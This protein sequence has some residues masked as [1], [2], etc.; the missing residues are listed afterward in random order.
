MLTAQ[1]GGVQPLV[2]RVDC[3]GKTCLVGATISLT[4]EDYGSVTFIL[5]SVN[6]GEPS[7]LILILSARQLVPVLL[8]HIPWI[9]QGGSIHVVH[10]SMI[11]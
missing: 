9:G 2:Q 5:K 1:F 6:S 10:Y 7:C 3:Y 8:P 11:E 4:V